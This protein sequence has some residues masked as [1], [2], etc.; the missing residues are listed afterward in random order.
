MLWLDCPR[1]GRRPLDEFVVRRRAADGA[2]LD[3]RRRRTRLRR[4]LDLREPR[5]RDDRALVPRGRLPALADG[6]PRHEHRPR[7]RGRRVTGL[8]DRRLEL[9]PAR[10]RPVRRR[11]AVARLPE[12]VREAGGT[13]GRSSS[14][15]PASSR[16]GSSTDALDV[17]DAGRAPTGVFAEVEPNPRD[18]IRGAR[19]RGAARVR[20]RRARS[21][22]P[23]AA[24]R[25]WT[26]RR[27]SRSTPPTA[28]TSWRS[29]IRRPAIWCRVAR[30]SPSR[31]PPGTGAETHTV[32]GHH[33]RGG[34]PQGLRRPSSR[35]CP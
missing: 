12:L 25:R 35:F 29:G 34:R 10:P 13:P 18:A 17:L 14:P 26:R 15:T 21:S 33:R 24:A 8:A 27:P 30:S 6:P 28:A 4:G 19:E 31:R 2:R 22:S 3:Q 5:R 9:R 16:P 11:G 1:C 23:S 32:R 7:A 20:D